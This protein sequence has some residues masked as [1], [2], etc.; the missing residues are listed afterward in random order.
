[1]RR[2]P[3]RSRDGFCEPRTVADRRL[4]AQNRLKQL[5]EVVRIEL[6]IGILHDEDPTP[7]MSYRRA[8]RRTL[9]AVS[10][11]LDV[12]NHAPRCQA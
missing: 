3:K 5:G 1:M 12:S 11:M 9:S 4:T 10:L 7:S 2:M 6:E 8:D